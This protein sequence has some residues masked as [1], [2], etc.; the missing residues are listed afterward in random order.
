MNQKATVQPIGVFNGVALSAL[1]MGDLTYLV[2][3]EVS[4]ALG[5]G[6]PGR[7]QDFVCG[8]WANEFPEPDE[9]LEPSGTTTS[10]P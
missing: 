6:R 1:V 8:K 7:I 3:S 9:V 4:L 10:K 2:A 5:Y